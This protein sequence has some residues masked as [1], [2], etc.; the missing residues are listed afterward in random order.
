MKILRKS[1]WTFDTSA[2]GGAGYGMFS[3]EGGI[4]VLDDLEG[5]RHRYFFSAFGLSLSWALTSLLRIP[6]LA[7]PKIIVK[8]DELSGSAATSNFKSYGKLFL[9]E[10]FKGV[11]LKDPRSL[12]GGTVY[13][14]GAGGYLL[15]GN[16]SLMMLGISRALLLMG[17]A[18]PDLIGMAIRSAPAALTMAG[19]NEG[20]QNMAALAFMPGQITY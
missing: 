9:T 13:L 18:K 4:F 16:G 3:T 8:G 5:N 1:G 6:K 19:V 17:V 10:S 14:E 11:D 12:E 7:L 2:G 20:L 15:G